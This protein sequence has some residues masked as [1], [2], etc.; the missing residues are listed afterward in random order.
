MLKNQCFSNCMVNRYTTHLT[1]DAL[2]WAFDTSLR[3]RR[4]W[5]DE[6]KHV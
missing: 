2:F 1:L 4:W 6:A 5:H 3:Q